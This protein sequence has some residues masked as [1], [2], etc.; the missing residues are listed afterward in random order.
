MAFCSPEDLTDLWSLPTTTDSAGRH[1]VDNE[2]SLIGVD[3]DVLNRDYSI[4]DR[5][6]RIL[7]IEFEP[8]PSIRWDSPTE[9]LLWL[10]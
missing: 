4:V 6:K 10:V 8:M 2:F 9:D 3:S 7:I 5:S 1:S